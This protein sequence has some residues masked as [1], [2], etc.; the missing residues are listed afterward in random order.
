MEEDM[1]IGLV[2]RLMEREGG[3]VDH[4]NDRGGPTNMG[5]TI[6]TLS[7]WR[8][9]SVTK[10]EVKNLTFHEASRIYRNL[11]WTRPGFAQLEITC[12]CKEML[13]DAAVHHGPRRAARLL[14]RA[15]GAK[16]DGRLGPLSRE[17]VRIHPGDVLA[18][19]FMAARVH[20][21]GKI[22]TRLPKQA[23]F[24]AGW[25]KRMQEFILLIPEA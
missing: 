6:K 10:E 2:H 25:M 8:D 16:I 3:Y 14:Q 12:I 17:A 11:Y 21:I 24:A 1:I 18:A 23:V 20:Y 7:A 19:G 9:Y 5:V 15:A 4:P 13:F 22:I